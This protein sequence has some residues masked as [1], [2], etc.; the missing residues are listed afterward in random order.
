MDWQTRFFLIGFMVVTFIVLWV[1][2][3]P[4]QSK[5][6]R[7]M[8]VQRRWTEPVFSIGMIIWGAGIWYLLISQDNHSNTLAMVMAS[9][10]IVTGIYYLLRQILKKGK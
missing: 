4:L 6:R 8:M 1:L 9:L 10:L 3:R 5:L 2:G 7:G